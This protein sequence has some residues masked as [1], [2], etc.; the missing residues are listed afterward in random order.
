M[1][2]CKRES[3]I[4]SFS[5]HSRG[6]EEGQIHSQRHKLSISRGKARVGD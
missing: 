5:I 2:G 6:Q 3:C 1:D 4:E